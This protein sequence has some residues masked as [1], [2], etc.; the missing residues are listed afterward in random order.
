MEA[1]A[2]GEK[3]FLS[4]LVWDFIIL[5]C[6]LEV[7]GSNREWHIYTVQVWELQFNNVPGSIHHLI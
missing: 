7:S 5:N 3:L 6:L 4:Q 1:T 2:L